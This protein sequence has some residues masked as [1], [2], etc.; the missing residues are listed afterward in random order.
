MSA[1]SIYYTLPPPPQKNP[2]KEIL[3]KIDIGS[4]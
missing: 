2:P 3:A 1:L 4:T